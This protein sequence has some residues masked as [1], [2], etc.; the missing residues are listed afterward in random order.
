[1]QKPKQL[2]ALRK[3]FETIESTVMLTINSWCFEGKMEH[4]K[5]WTMLAILFYYFNNVIAKD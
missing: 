2:P 3:H 5:S 1:M 4:N